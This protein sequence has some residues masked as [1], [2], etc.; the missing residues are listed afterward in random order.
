MKTALITGASSGIGLDSAILL[1]K[2][3]YKII[4]VGRNQEKLDECI[5]SCKGDANFS[6]KA[7][8]NDE[9]EVKSFIKEL[10]NENVRLDAVICCAGKHIVKPIRISKLKDYSTLMENNFYSFT[11]VLC[12]IS[13]ILNKDASIVAVSSAGVMR[14]AA[15]VSAY[16]ASKKAIEGFIKSAAIE[17]AQNKI[18]VNAIAPGVVLTE[19]TEGFIK[20]IG[21]RA[22]KDMK[23]SHPLGFGKP[24]DVS[25][26]I[27]FLVSDRSVW[28]TGQTVVIDGGFSIN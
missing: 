18:R 12:N 11:N 22:A 27:E 5:K 28:I 24:R 1:S 25:N 26:L 20:S 13:K 2:M 6:I 23:D 3:G 10:K 17:F 21:E 4:A 8:L 15:A 19:M 7:S 14:S 9:K 16:A